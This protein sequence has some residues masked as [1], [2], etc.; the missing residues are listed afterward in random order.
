MPKSHY[1]DNLI[2]CSQDVFEVEQKTIFSKVWKFVCCESE[3]AQPYDYRTVTVA[4]IPLIVSRG[5]DST[6]RAMVN[7][8]SHRGVK[9][10]DQPS[11]SAR[12]FECLFH[13]WTYDDK[14]ACVYIPSRP[15]KKSPT[16]SSVP[17]TM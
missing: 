16:T 9:L 2:Y 1:I 10:V 17:G 14:G 3:I 12:R 13:H 15:L 7:S 11:G 4:G 8:C 6:I 5:S